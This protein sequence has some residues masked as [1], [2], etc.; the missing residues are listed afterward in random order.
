MTEANTWVAASQSD[1]S[2]DGAL[3]HQQQMPAQRARAFALRFCCLRLTTAARNE[4]KIECATGVVTRGSKSEPDGHGAFGVQCI[5]DDD[6]LTRQ[7]LV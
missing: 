2:L 4:S 5:F 3:D 7:I 6:N 1:V